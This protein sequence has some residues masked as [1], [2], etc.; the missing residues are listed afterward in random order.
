MTKKAASTVSHLTQS[1]KQPALYDRFW[2]TFLFLDL[3]VIRE[4]PY[5]M[6]DKFFELYVQFGSNQKIWL[7][8]CDLVQ[9]IADPLHVLYQNIVTCNHRFT[10]FKL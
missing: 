8:L 9:R 5:V 2:T 6:S 7:Y 4:M 10:T 3:V 1:V